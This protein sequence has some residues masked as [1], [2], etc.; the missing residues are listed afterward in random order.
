MSP[1]PGSSPALF[2]P[3]CTRSFANARLRQPVVYKVKSRPDSVRVLAR[4]RQW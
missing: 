3:F 4:L 1:I 2:L